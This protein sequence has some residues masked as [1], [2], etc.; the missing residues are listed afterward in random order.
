MSDSETD[1]ED[2]PIPPPRRPRFHNADSSTTLGTAGAA[3]T[4]TTGAAAAAPPVLTR[5]DARLAHQAASMLRD[6]AGMSFVFSSPSSQRAP[7]CGNESCFLDDSA[8]EALAALGAAAAGKALRRAVDASRRAVETALGGPIEQA[9]VPMASVGGDGIWE[10]FHRGVD[11]LPADAAGDSLLLTAV[12]FLEDTGDEAAARVLP[13]EEAVAGPAKPVG[14]K[15]AR[16]SAA[17]TAASCGDG[18]SFAPHA[19]QILLLAPG[20]VRSL[21]SGPL[22][23]TTWWR[24][25][26]LATA[27]QTKGAGAQRSRPAPGDAAAGVRVYDGVLATADRRKLAEAPLVRWAVYDRFAGSGPRNAHERGIESLLNALGDGSRWVEYWGRARWDAIPAH[28]DCDEAGPLRKGGGEARTPTNAHVLYL[29][30]AEGVAAPT[31]L[32]AKGG[33][34]GG[35]SRS[36]LVVVPA[37]EGRLLRFDGSWVHGV[38]RPAREYLGENDADEHEEAEAGD[39]A[40]AGGETGGEEEEEE[41]G[42]EE[43]GEEE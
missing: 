29:A 15:R 5:K 6:V 22:T 26:R 35:P 41:E 9:S 16:G 38:P 12:A 39:E 3:L 43:E 7:P 14:R 25:P 20:A 24:R 1:A 33:V 4:G 23:L 40:E 8:F 18:V 10:R 37:V 42:G 17:A 30:K 2:H 11:G 31:V 28:F 21:R 36:E 34:E 19:G 32:W 27:Q 13:Q